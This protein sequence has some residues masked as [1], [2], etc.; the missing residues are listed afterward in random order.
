[1]CRQGHA[2]DDLG[3]RAGPA[4]EASPDIEQPRRRVRVFTVSAGKRS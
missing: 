1:M 2:L 3:T 4:I